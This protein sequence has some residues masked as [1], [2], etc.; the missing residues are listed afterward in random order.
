MIDATGP[1]KADRPPRA[2]GV[3]PLE[4]SREWGACCAGSPRSTPQSYKG[5]TWCPVCE[6]L[7]AQR[8]ARSG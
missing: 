5:I 6:W 1:P 7:E 4:R 2:M 3:P 8:T